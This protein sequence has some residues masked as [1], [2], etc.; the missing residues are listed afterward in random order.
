MEC[1][2]VNNENLIELYAK[3]Y[4]IF[5]DT[6]SIL[7][8]S[9]DKF[10]KNIIPYLQRYN[11]KII[12]SVRVYEELK[13]HS[14]NL[15][16]NKLSNKANESLYNIKKLLN[17][18]VIELRGEP[19]DN[20]A[21]NLFKEIFTK[22]RI[23]YKL[24]L[25][26][27][28]RDLAEGILTLNNDRFVNANNVSVKKIDKFGF[29]IDFNKKDE[30]EI[31]PD[32]IFRV[33]KNVTSLNDLNPN[34]RDI[35]NIPGE[36][37]FVYIK[38]GRQG[39]IELLEKI[40]SGGEGVI[41]K[42]NTYYIAKIYKYEKNT[43]RKHEKIKLMLSKNI[44][45]E[46]I[47][48][49]VSPLYNS[50][51]EFVGYLMPKA[52]GKEIQKSIFIK[53][54]LLKNFPNW[55]KRDL[56]ELCITILNKIKYLHNRNIIIGDINPNNILIVSPKEVYFVDTDS[57]QIEEFPCPVGTINFTA[58]EIQGKDFKNFLRTVGNENFAIATLLFMIMLPG[59]PPYSQQG[60]GSPVENIKNMEFSYPL[61]ENSNK[62]TPDGAWRFIWS[63]L[64][65]DLK[66]AFYNTFR[67]EGEN[68]KEDNRLSVSEWLTIFKYY[69]KLL[70]SG[71]FGN[72]DKMSED[73]FP[74]RYK[75]IEGINY[76]KCTLCNNEVQ[77]KHSK[78]GICRTCLNEGEI[79]VCKN[80]G[81]EFL[82]SNYN[83]YIKNI[84]KYDICKD[85]F[86]YG[87]EI[88]EII[89][90]CDCGKEFEITNNEYNYY[91]NKWSN[92][93][94]RCSLCR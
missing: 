7:Y 21:D 23:K 50:N 28:D 87:N 24:L 38:Q 11:N 20:F 25:I 16:N 82:F 71:T 88:R 85:C 2:E 67:K 84:K 91:I 13:K 40:S 43:K 56:V 75:K 46:G 29:L 19:N 14:E 68:S 63:H 55:K 58:P 45:F 17:C 61:G 6:C 74:T 83:K 59:K 90:C 73:L 78:N 26:T 32:E 57:Y 12:I 1:E 94:K 49:P 31:N 35:K 52:E 30:E 41:Y 89:N 5:I 10:W 53:Q 93:P 64:T 39:E 33:C 22:H 34:V 3:D 18:G 72:R 15:K 79:V 66:E 27:Q 37:E 51:D 62:K 76:I 36:K 77:E 70:D 48:F 69:L 4:K 65:Y 9:V 54:L 86:N 44:N 8:D 42:T 80:C 81:K 60:G 47:C 92:I